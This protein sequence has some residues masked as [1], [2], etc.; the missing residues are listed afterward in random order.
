MFSCKE[1]KKQKR[2]QFTIIWI[3]FHSVFFFSTCL[4]LNNQLGCKNKLE[5]AKI[6]FSR[7]FA[8]NIPCYLITLTAIIYPLILM[9]GGFAHYV[10]SLQLMLV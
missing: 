7:L 4:N 3:N 2:V 10:T 6:L 8:D 1:I 9:H 5:N